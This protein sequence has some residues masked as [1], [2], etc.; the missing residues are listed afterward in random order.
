MANEVGKGVVPIEPSVDGFGAALEQGIKR[1]GE[2]AAKEGARQLQMAMAGVFAAG[3]AAL[4]K[5]VFDSAGFDR[6]MREVF[7]LLPDITGEAMGTMTDDVK[8]FATEF[9]ILPQD[10]VPALYSSLSA[11]VPADNVFD[12]METATKLAKGGVTELEVA[13]DG[14][15]S[16]VN[17]YGADV[18]PAQQA[19]DLLFTTVKLGKTTVAELSAAIFQVTPTAAALG[20]EFGNVTAALAAM[21]L[22]GVP[23]SVATTQLRQL[24]VELSKSG[25]GTAK[26][27]E[28]LAGKTFKQFIAEGGDLQG[29]LQMLETHAADAGLGI[30]DLFGSV[31]AGGA[32]LALTGGG[33]EAFTNA[34]AGMADSAGATDAAFETMNQG[35][36]V[37]MDRL[38]A[39]FAVSLINIGDAIAPTVAVIGE[40]LGLLLELFSAL[41]GPMQAFG[42]IFITMSA[43]AF[44]FSR[45]I[46][47]TVQILKSLSSVMTMLSANPWVL[48]LM[49]L[50]LIATAI[51]THWEEVKQFFSDLVDFLDALFYGWTQGQATQWEEWGLKV[52]EV[53]GSL[54]SF[55]TDGITG[56][57][58]VIGDAWGAITGATAAAWGA[59]YGTVTGVLNTVIGLITGIPNTV[60]TAFGNLADMIAAPFLA[61]FAA[62]KAAWNSTVGGFGFTAPSWIP[63]FGGNGFTI[64]RMAQG[65]VLTGPSLFMGGEYPGAAQNP[66]IVAPQSIMRETVVDAL[67]SV[68]APITISLVMNVDAGVTDPRFFEDRA[69]DIVRV[70]QRELDRDRRAAGRPTTGVAA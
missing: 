65:G 68:G 13:V 57:G 37:T 28:E 70:V 35:L 48:G 16:V 44:A 60:T 54:F 46:V 52:R 18:L 24:F 6:Q 30:N 29:A 58:M 64:P 55:I 49:A 53:I 51:I 21:T 4:T 32:A 42:L 43:G 59:I 31:E 69:T 12:F 45:Q 62:I 26:V 17:A 56:L 14:L 50:V 63:G 33:T 3:A 66:E 23:T 5:S 8:A 1:E 39:Q 40:G 15:T 11:G 7:T 34:L 9:A 41:P 67:T 25:S 27:F 19:S 22:Q 20:V 38:K 10:V 61:A 2:P 47:A 36:A